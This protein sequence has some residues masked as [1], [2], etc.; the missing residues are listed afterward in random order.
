MLQLKKA[1]CILLVALLLVQPVF[2]KEKTEAAQPAEPDIVTAVKTM[3]RL[4]GELSPLSAQSPEKQWLRE[5]TT[6]PLYAMASDG[7]WVCVLAADLPE[8]VTGSYAGTHGIPQGA[9]RHYA[10]RIALNGAACWADGT[11]ITADDCLFSVKQLLQGDETAEDW[12]F[13]ANASGI[14]SGQQKQGT[15]IISLGEAGFSDLSEAWAAGFRDFYLDT[16]GFW[17]LDGG[18][19]S[20]SDRTRIQDYAMPGGLDE[21]FVSPAYLYNRYLMNGAQLSRDQSTFLGICST[22]GETLT[23]E[24]LGLLRT[25]ARELVV[26]SESPMTVSVLMQKLES[27]FLFREAVYSAG[28]GKISP[29]YPAYGPYRIT[30]AGA[31]EIILEPNPNWWGDPDPRGYD[32]I[33]CQKIGS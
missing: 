7:T 30:G 22:P 20:I 10:Y 12:L 23:M 8:D 33:V 21:G 16:D 4:P 19:R 1:L 25:G 32:R 15:D 27:L 11:P 24:D 18:W 3:A 13:L 2:A 28:Y 31:E 6:A 5:L 17:G 29:D 9:Q 26:I 14:L